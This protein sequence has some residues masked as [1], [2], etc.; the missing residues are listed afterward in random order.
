MPHR[1]KFY[2]L[3]SLSLITL[4]CTKSR[5][6]APLFEKVSAS[7][8]GIDFENQL[9]YDEQLNAYTYKNFYNG[10][11]VSLGDI[12]NDGLTDIYFSGNLV[13]NKLYLNKGNFQ[14]EDITESAGVSCKNVWSSGVSM[15][16]VNGDG[17]LDIFVCKSGPLEGEH[18]YNQLFINNGDLTFTD[19]AKEYGVDEIGLSIHAAFFDYDRDGDLD[20]Y[21]LNN[22]TRSVG[23]YD[24]R[25][26]QR[27]VR[28]PNGGNK[29]YRND[30]EIFTDVSEEAGIYGS[31][32]GFGLGVTVADINQ[33]NWPDI[34]VSNDFFERDYLYLNNQDGTFTESLE[35][36]IPETSMG[37][38]GADITDLNDDGYPEIYVTEMLPASQERVKTK[39]LF[40]SWDKYQANVNSGY[41]HQFTRNTLQQNLGIN[42]ENNKEVVFSEISRQAGVHAT[43][44]SWGALMFDYDNDGKSD[45]FVANGVVKDLT[46]QDYINFYANNTLL[47]EQY[48]A[49]SL[50]VTKLLDAIPSVPLQNHLFQNQGDFQ[51]EDKAEQA[52]LTDK[53]F[54][55]GA[56][57][58]DLDNDGDLDLIVN[59]INSPALIYRNLSSQNTENHYLQLGFESLEAHQLFGT[60]VS[61]YSGELKLTKEFH[62]VKGYMS[63]MDHILHFG[64]G[65][66]PKVDRIAITW[67]DD[68]ESELLN[69][70]V[71]QKIV[72]SKKRLEAKPSHLRTSQASVFKQT[73][74]QGEFTHTENQFIDFDRDRLLFQ[75]SSNEGP[76]VAIGDIN[77]DKLED[78]F[79]GGAKGFSGKIHLQ[80][81]DGSF[82]TTL[83]NQD[84]LSEDIDASFI[85]LDKD[86]DLDLI[87]ASGGYEYGALDPVLQDRIYLNDGKAN[88]E[89]MPW[90]QFQS[91]SESSAFL[92]PI[93]FDGDGDLDLVSGTRST[94]FAYGIPGSIHLY[95]N[96]NQTFNEVKGVTS[97]KEVGMMTD[98]VVSDID[99]DGDDDL[100]VLGEWMGIKVF[101]NHQGV[102]EVEEIPISKGLW[103][104]LSIADMNN[105]GLLDI[106]AGNHGLNSRL[107]A[108]IDHPLS[109]YVNDFDQNGSIE[110][111]ITQFEGETSY[112]IVLLPDLV[113]QL[114]GLRKKY[115]KHESYKDQTIEDIFDQETLGNS[116]KSQ[117][118]ELR[119]SIFFQE[120][121][122]GFRKVPV[123]AEAQ[124]SQVF[125]ILPEDVNDDGLIDLIIGGNQTRMKP[126]MGINNG[127]Y[128]LTLLN[129]GNEDFKALKPSES[130]ILVRND[131]RQIKKIEIRGEGVFLFVRSNESSL[132]YKKV[133][134]EE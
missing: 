70:A 64:L 68:S 32:I 11:G 17:L 110:Q 1:L 104:S 106:I 108:D 41:H 74:I 117:A 30:G 77:G 126:E 13:D 31:A 48:R 49:D 51:F 130:G 118:N 81:V 46:D 105:D 124:F 55:N 38:M 63:S 44:W 47:F 67:P 50:V 34:F 129:L 73:P 113:K 61:V 93:D 43:D 3:F 18:R 2:L 60:K 82:T 26:G 37:S 65:S 7:E 79:I 80:K 109:I 22:S 125:S 121:N 99:G 88:F 45:I 134:N 12:N 112:P 95:E 85:D 20:L 91:V 114:P 78:L 90:T 97:F 52:G 103:H 101:S 53:A 15:A 123:P 71:D 100:I 89:R 115:V 16:D 83:L 75:M 6:K 56:A 111:I 94:P 9:E 42:P 96:N 119:T 27:E 120:P 116:L 87:V 84:L 8:S 133:I 10:A 21:L 128:G 127:S 122:G 5:D 59:N 33:D 35:Q 39:T 92:K 57:Y 62:P 25:Q 102:F 36:L 24:L 98:G 54:S 19:K 132:A 4:G 76:A 14:F 58:G 86:G 107:K 28:D 23:G 131:T 29:L 66:L 69:V 40:E 72:L